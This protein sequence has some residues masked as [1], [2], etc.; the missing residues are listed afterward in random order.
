MR[1]KY[2]RTAEYNLTQMPDH[3]VLV[4][5]KGQFTIPMEYRRKYM[6]K[7][8]MKVLVS[9]TPR[10]ILLRPIPPLEELAGVDA[11]KVTV[12]EMKKRLDEMRSE[13]R[14]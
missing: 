4:T 14:Y 8:G 11:G 5:R 1:P 12:Q 2:Y 9:D 13:D 7:E 10:G 3:V 6:I